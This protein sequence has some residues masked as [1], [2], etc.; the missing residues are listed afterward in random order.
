M[1]G[2]DSFFLKLLIDNLCLLYVFFLTG[3]DLADRSDGVVLLGEVDESDTLG[4]TSHD[5]YVGY[6]QTNQHARLVGQTMRRIVALYRNEGAKSKALA[7]M[8]QAQKIDPTNIELTLEAAELYGMLSL[9]HEA[10]LQLNACLKQC[11]NKP[12]S[13]LDGEFFR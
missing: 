3:H 1:R 13:E 7:V 11:E 2:I 6:L 9:T 10:T 5:A 4:G 12:Q 8:K